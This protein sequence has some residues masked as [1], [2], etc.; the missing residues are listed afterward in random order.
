MKAGEM[1]LQI[2]WADSRDGPDGMGV[3]LLSAGYGTDW[4]S[5]EDRRAHPSVG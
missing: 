2:T 5:G 1:T 3:L 4:V